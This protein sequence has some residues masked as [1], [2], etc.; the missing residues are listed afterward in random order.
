M[1]RLIFLLCVLI[2]ACA[3][4]PIPTVRA[5]MTPSVTARVYRARPTSLP[6]GRPS[7]T[8]TVTGA[9][10]PPA[11][12]PTENE[13]ALQSQVRAALAQYPGDWHI[14]VRQ[15][16]GSSLYSYQAEQRIDAAS[17]IKIPIALLFL[18]TIPPKIL[19][20]L[21]EYLSSKGLDGRTFE[22]LLRAMLVDSE[23]EATISLL[24]AIQN[25]NLNVNITLQGWGATHTNIYT[26]KTTTEDIAAL[27][28]GFY[29]GELLT[30]AARQVLLTH[31]AEYTEGDDTRIGVIRRALPC[32][33]QFYNKRGTIIKEYL[34]VADVAILKFPTAAGEQAYFMALFAYPGKSGA[35]YESLVQG[36]EKLAHIFWGE[37]ETQNALP[38]DAG[39]QP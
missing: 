10:S 18:K 26:R 39:C 14:L 28:D 21:K 6:V 3:P 24:T 11:A 38:R 17:I 7:L 9:P 32:D 37:I 35:T 31:M 36:M 34:A 1:R 23:E 12:T 27:V 22:Q 30:P 33:G 15:V 13:T 5:R 2:T 20:A 19:P 4:A 8:P 25:S 16:G 29:A